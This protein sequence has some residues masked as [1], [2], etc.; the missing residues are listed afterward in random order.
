MLKNMKTIYKQSIFSKQLRTIPFKC[1]SHKIGASGSSDIESLMRDDNG[2][3]LLLSLIAKN[4]LLEFPSF[5]DSVLALNSIE[6]TY[7]NNVISVDDFI[8][9]HCSIGAK[10]LSSS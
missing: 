6:M 5:T 1:G 4:Y 8:I 3:L 10:I 9:Q 2:S 7:F